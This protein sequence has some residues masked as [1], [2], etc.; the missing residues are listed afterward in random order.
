MPQFRH[1]EH[2]YGK[3]YKKEEN[4]LPAKTAAMP[5][6]VKAYNLWG[7]RVENMDLLHFAGIKTGFRSDGVEGWS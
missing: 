6:S 4:R 2:Y 1:P 7:M 5:G 3:R